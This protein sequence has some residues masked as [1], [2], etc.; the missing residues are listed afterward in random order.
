MTTY[1]NYQWILQQRP[2]GLVKRS[3]FEFRESVLRPRADGECVVKIMYMAMDPATRGWMSPGGGY[4]EPLPLGGPVLGVTI[5]KVVESR[6]PQIREGT[7]VAGVGEWGKYMIAGPQQ[8]AAVRAG[9]HGVLAPMDTSTGHE[10]PMYLHAMGTSG[11]TAWY[12]LIDVAG[13]KAGD[14]VLVSGATGSV[15]QLVTQ[16]AKLKGAAKVVG[17]AGGAAKCAE[18]VRDYGCDACIDYKATKD[19]SSAIGREF[20]EGL[21]V[22]F[23]NVGGDILEAALDHLAKRARVAICGMISRYNDSTP[24][25]GPKNL[26]NLLVHTARIEGFLVSDWFGTAGSEDAYLQISEWLKQGSLKAKLDIRS[27]FDKVPDVF[28]LLFTGGN[29]G[30]LVVKVPD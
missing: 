17:I 2:E 11:G 22:Y 8:I 6:N 1:T 10:L 28:N 23:D 15:G 26:W 18:A 7:V 19:I 4:A 24:S 21:D 13:M 29:D 30:R 12:G 16:M 20:P 14:R 25:P 5:G 3:D 27:D 9:A